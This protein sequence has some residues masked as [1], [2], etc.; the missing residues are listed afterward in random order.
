M[1]IEES[2]ARALA[3]GIICAGKR[4]GGPRRL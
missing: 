2:V 4:H 3:V 1:P